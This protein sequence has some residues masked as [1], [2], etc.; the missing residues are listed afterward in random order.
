MAEHI[1]GRFRTDMI[2]TRQVGELEI[3]FFDKETI[4]LVDSNRSVRYI[5]HRW[6]APRKSYDAWR[7]F[8][9]ALWKSNHKEIGWY[10]EESATWD[11]PFT[12]T[13]RPLDLSNKKIRRL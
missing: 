3:I 6:F 10:F 9:N 13:T 12:A 8:R 4:Y 7:S 2:T 11:I 1:N 5:F